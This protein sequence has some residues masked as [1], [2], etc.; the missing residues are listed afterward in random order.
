MIEEFEKVRKW[1]DI[2][3]IGGA[4][5]VQ[6][7]YQRVLQEVVEIHDGICNN[8]VEEIKD[9]IGDS[10]VTLINLAKH[11][12][13][14]AEE[15]LESA[16]GVIELRKGITTPRGDF[17]RYGKLSEEDKKWCDEH[18]GNPGNQ[19]FSEDMLKTLKPED[20]KKE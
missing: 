1:S 11:Y 8:D 6:V 15:C 7:Q 17:V 20:F 19:Y 5:D 3:G 13:F 16:F 10:I 2:R 12:D 18:Q 4:K 14:T 9:A